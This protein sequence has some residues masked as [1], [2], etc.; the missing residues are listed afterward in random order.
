[1]IIEGETAKSCKA[2]VEHLKEHSD[3]RRNAQMVWKAERLDRMLVDHFLRSGYYETAMLMA[4]K[5]DIEVKSKLLFT[6]QN[7]FLTQVVNES[8]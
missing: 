5:A 8:N 4:K 1:M 3:T 6:L 7:D 2:R